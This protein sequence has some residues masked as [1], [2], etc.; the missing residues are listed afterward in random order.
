MWYLEKP[1]LLRN[2]DGK[3]R[4]RLKRTAGLLEQFYRAAWNGDP[5]F[6]LQSSRAGQTSKGKLNLKRIR[7]AIKHI[8]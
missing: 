5:V 6:L 1:N 3:P 8:Q 7:F 2:R 4:I